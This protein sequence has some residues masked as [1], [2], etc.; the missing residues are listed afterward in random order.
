MKSM[1]QGLGLLHMASSSVRK[2]SGGQLKRL[3]IACGALLKGAR[4]IILDEVSCCDAYAQFL[5]LVSCECCSE[6]TGGGGGSVAHCLLCVPGGVAANVRAEFEGR[7]RLGVVPSNHCTCDA[8]HCAT[9]YPPAAC[10]RVC[11]AR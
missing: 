2:L 6:H 5:C 8:G 11:G 4:I 7:H 1:L 9:D 10:Q 3:V